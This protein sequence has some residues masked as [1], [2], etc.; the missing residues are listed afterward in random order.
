MNDAQ[1]QVLVLTVVAVLVFLAVRKIRRG[2][3]EDEAKADAEQK[4]QIAEGVKRGVLHLNGTPICVSCGGQA[5]EPTVVTGR[6]WFDQ[7]P[8]IQHVNRL[9]G[10]PWRYTVVEA[11]E[12]GARFCVNCKRMAREKLEQAHA[13]IRAE[14]AQFNADQQDKLAMLDNGGLEDLVAKRVG[15]IRR[16]VGIGRSILTVGE[17]ETHQ[18]PL[19]SSASQRA[20]EVN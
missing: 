17:S 1:I 16:A 13:Q 14:H 7:I 3:Q 12:L 20:E 6:P 4:E 10:L 19:T 8:I 11:P 5:T 18:L 2:L 15:E 9:Y